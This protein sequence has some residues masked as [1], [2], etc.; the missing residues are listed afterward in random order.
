MTG[1]HIFNTINHATLLSTVVLRLAI[2]MMKNYLKGLWHTSLSALMDE[3]KASP[4]HLL[5]PIQAFVFLV[6]SLICEGKKVTE[7]RLILTTENV[8]ANN[9]VSVIVY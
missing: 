1:D 3:N 7:S 5:C 6:P 8:G 9:W 2:V 4:I